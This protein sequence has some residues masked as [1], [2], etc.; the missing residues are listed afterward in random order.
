MNS[1]KFVQDRNQT[2]MKEESEISEEWWEYSQ[3][4][5]IHQKLLDIKH[6]LPY[7]RKATVKNCRE[8]GTNDN[9]TV[10]IEP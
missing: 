1:N 5:Y 9:T 8:E 3:P 2:Y 10:Y 6:G 4:I 7:I